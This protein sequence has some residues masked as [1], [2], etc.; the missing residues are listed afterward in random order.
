MTTRILMV[1][2]FA[3]AVSI[4]GTMLVYGLLVARDTHFGM[5]LVVVGCTL[6]VLGWCVLALL[7]VLGRAAQIRESYVMGYRH[8]RRDANAQLMED[9][10][11]LADRA[12]G[13]AS[14]RL[15]PQES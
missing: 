15:P 5:S 2:V 6:S 10:L 8:G 11:W 12:E 13:S 9:G 4:G 3:V 7:W 14:K 1:S